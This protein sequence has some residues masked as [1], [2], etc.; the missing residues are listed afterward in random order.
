MKRMISINDLVATGPKTACYRRLSSFHIESGVA[1]YWM[2]DKPAPSRA[3]R[4]RFRYN[5]D[6]VGG[7]YRQVYYYA[8]TSTPARRA[9]AQK[10][11]KSRKESGEMGGHGK[12]STGCVLFILVTEPAF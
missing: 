8:P 1:I 10:A 6:L 9:C 11:F 7:T 3:H 2:R 4:G 12:A 5:D